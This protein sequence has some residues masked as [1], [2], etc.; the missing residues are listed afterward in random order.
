MSTV[1]SNPTAS[2]ESL[3]TLYSQE[4]NYGPKNIRKLGPYKRNNGK[5][6]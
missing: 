6:W 3:K 4:K 5:E 2:V 1:G